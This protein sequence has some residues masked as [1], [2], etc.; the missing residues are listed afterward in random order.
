MDWRKLAYRRD[1][2]ARLEK[3]PDRGCDR[4]PPPGPCDR[5]IDEGK[6]ASIA[7]SYFSNALFGQHDKNMG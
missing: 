1:S 4:L 7:L 2:H 5:E 6:I 3:L